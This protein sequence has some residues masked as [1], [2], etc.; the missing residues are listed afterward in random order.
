MFP[1]VPVL[2]KSVYCD[3]ISSC[4][5]NF[6]H[7][8]VTFIVLAQAKEMYGSVQCFMHKTLESRKKTLL[9]IY[10]RMISE[11]NH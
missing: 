3:R 8:N 6:N 10:K 2:F 4:N 1:D 11:H 5:T 7:L 9:N